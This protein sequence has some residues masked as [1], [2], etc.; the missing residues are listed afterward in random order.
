MKKIIQLS[1][2]FALVINIFAQNS[3]QKIVLIDEFGVLGSEDISARVDNL[4]TELNNQPNSKAVIKI[5]G[6]QENSFALPYLRGATIKAL[7][8]NNNQMPIERFS[9][10]FCNVNQEPLRTQFFLVSANEKIGL[11]DEN[12]TVPRETVLYETLYSYSK[13]NN[14]SSEQP[15]EG[16]YFDVVGEGGRQYSQ[17]SQNALL[18]LISKSPESKIYLLGYFSKKDKKNKDK[19][20]VEKELIKNGISK[21]KII[22]IDGGYKG[23]TKVIE[24][25]FV[26]KGGKIPK[27]D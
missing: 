21:S 10:Q 3:E 12:L 24:I 2:V 27:P 8:K 13:E 4:R 20:A 18:N 25:W 14:F 16:A 26:P 6:G 11:C 15:I 9:I 22:K 1:L 17:I 5:Y 19:W 23:S 7:L